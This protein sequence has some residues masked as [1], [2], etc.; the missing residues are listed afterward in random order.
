[1]KKWFPESKARASSI[2]LFGF[3]LGALVFTQIQSHFINPN[4]YPPDEVYSPEF[5]NE[6]YFSKLHMDLLNRVPYCFLLI[7]G[8]VMIMQI[9]GTLL[10]SNPPE[11]NT[12]KSI[13]NRNFNDIDTSNDLS[14]ESIR[15]TNKL[16]SLGV[17]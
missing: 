15:S 7:S 10:M 6:K 14:V 5:P 13:I 16:N 8:I 4:N 3:G 1:M 12:L 11:E 9:I 17:E 2:V